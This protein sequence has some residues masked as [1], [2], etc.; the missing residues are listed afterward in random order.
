M[1]RQNHNG[2]RGGFTLI[3]LLVVIA[4]IA[5]LI[6]LL[7]P[8]I[9]KVREAAARVQCQNNLKQIGL[10]T[11]NYNDINAGLPLTGDGSKPAL[12]GAIVSVFYELLPYIEQQNLYNLGATDVGAGTTVNL[13]RCPSDASFLVGNAP[14]FC[15]Y[16]SNGFVFNPPVGVR[17]RIP[18]TFTDGT[19]NTVLFAEQLAQC[20][21][22]GSPGGKGGGSPPTLDFNYWG[23][24]SDANMFFPSLD[25]SI[26]PIL[27]GVSQSTC[28]TNNSARGGH[29]ITSTSH[30]S[31]M[32][33]GFGDGSVRGVS[34]AAAANTFSA[35]GG[36]TTLTAWY[37]YCTP[38]QGEVPPPL[39]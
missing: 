32:Q 34:Q 28:L 39:D 1:H 27:V 8:A 26:P 25:P 10:A 31:T 29:V 16:S 12:G 37:A 33:V 21:I 14:A 23:A 15:S 13:F 35:D 9:Q 4:I 17:A 36:V 30:T 18:G 7:L 20:F 38:D 6:G 11:H 24:L 3:E 5:V 22:P 2:D 19:S